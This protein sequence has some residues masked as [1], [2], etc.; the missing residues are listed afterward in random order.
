MRRRNLLQ[1]KYKHIRY[2]NDGGN[3][4]TA[5]SQK[6]IDET[7]GSLPLDGR[8]LLDVSKIAK[9]N[10]VSSLTVTNAA[11][12][13]FNIVIGTADTMGRI[14]KVLP[15][16]TDTT[17]W[18]S[19]KY[20]L[21]GYINASVN[22]TVIFDF[23]DINQNEVAINATTTSTYFAVTFNSTNNLTSPYYGFIDV[24]LPTAPTANITF[25]FGRLKLEVGDKASAWSP[26]NLVD[27]ENAENNSLDGRNLVQGVADE[28]KVFSYTGLYD[29]TY[30]SAVT[31]RMPPDRKVGDKF[32]FSAEAKL[33][34]ED[35]TKAWIFIGGGLAISDS[36]ADSKWNGIPGCGFPTSLAGKGWSKVS[37][38]FKITSDNVI[39]AT[40]PCGI[41]AGSLTGTLQVKNIQLKRGDSET[42]WTPSPEDC[43][44]GTTE[45]KYMG[46]LVWDKPY[47]SNNPRDYTWRTNS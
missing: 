36:G 22:T 21:S 33:E 43:T 14:Q 37:I 3:T 31:L 39:Y 2:S 18:G 35:V 20:V 17:K 15:F 11:T 16:V 32:I 25:S 46:T 47:P 38:I 24:N 29:V 7:K 12:N 30:D 45:G 44:F 26:T 9:G 1:N 10:N 28:S 5:A 42:T 41:Q 13:T 6:A 27:I 4:F 40:K 8:N 34:A 23:G 19:R